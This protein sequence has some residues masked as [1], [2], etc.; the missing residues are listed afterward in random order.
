M[1]RLRLTKIATPSTPPSS[2]GEL[3]YQTSDGLLYFLDSSGTA[4]KL[5]GRLLNVRVFTTDQAPITITTGTKQIVWEAIGC[6]GG[7]GGAAGAANAAAAG[8]G[9]S[10]SYALKY[11]TTGQA[12]YNIVVQQSGLGTGGAAGN[13]NGAAGT[14]AAVTN[15]NTSATIVQ[16]KAGSGGTGSAT[17]VAVAETAG[18]A[19]GTAAGGTGDFKTEGNAGGV[20]IRFSGTQGL[21]GFG[22]A[23]PWGGGVSGRGVTGAGT[24]GKAFGAGGSGGL[25]VNGGA[26]QAGGN[27]A[28][29]VVRMWEFA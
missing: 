20:G 21:S 7:G 16:A 24:A 22:A 4:T 17:G 5:T 19:G 2:T 8:G 28:D 27:G 23:S 1:S 25:T 6:G 18:G 29:G 14:D 9:G 11:D 15:A 26:A 13:N 3:F 12:T 10:G